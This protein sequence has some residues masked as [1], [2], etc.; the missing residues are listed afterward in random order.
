MNIYYVSLSTCNRRFIVV[1]E[2]VSLRVEKKFKPRENFPMSTLP[3][4]YGSLPQDVTKETGTFC[5]KKEG[6]YPY[7]T[8]QASYRYR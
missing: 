7:E 1:L 2:L 8:S 6:G 5:A 3:F 4:L